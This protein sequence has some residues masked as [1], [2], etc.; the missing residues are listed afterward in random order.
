M[1][2]GVEVAEFGWDLSLRA[3]SRRTLSM[4]SIWLREEGEGKN[5]DQWNGNRAL[6][7]QIWTE[8]SA[9]RGGSNIDPTLGFNLEGRIS[10][11]GKSKRNME[12]NHSQTAMEH[13][14]EK[15]VIFGEEG[16]KRSRGAIE[17]SSSKEGYVALPPRTRR[18]MGSDNRLSV[19]AIRQADRSQ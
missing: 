2:L 16:K 9:E 4:T 10:S 13:D 11:F 18:G 8:E 7:N 3:Q 6:R 15:G 1:L 17:K 19:A 12:V 14:L 5:E